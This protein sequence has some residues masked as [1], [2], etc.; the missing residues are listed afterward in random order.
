MIELENNLSNEYVKKYLKIKKRS[1]FHF[2][3]FSLTVMML[4]YIKILVVFNEPLPIYFYTFIISLS[5]IC[6]YLL[7]REYNAANIKEIIYDNSTS[8]NLV[9]IQF[10]KEQI[11]LF[12]SDRTYCIHVNKYTNT[13][14]FVLS[15][16]DNVIFVSINT[17]FMLSL[18]NLTEEQ[19]CNLEKLFQYYKSN[20]HMCPV[21]NEN[22]LFECKIL[23]TR[24]KHILYIIQNKLKTYS[25]LRKFDI[26]ILILSI[27]D[28]F[29]IRLHIY[30]ILIVRLIIFLMYAI[31][32]ANTRYKYDIQSGYIKQKTKIKFTSKHYIITVNDKIISRENIDNIFKIEKLKNTYYIQTVSDRLFIQDQDNDYLK[33]IMKKNK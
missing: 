31:H 17:I 3:C 23:N 20:D 33:K 10:T 1:G 14:N 32:T 6:L 12:Y 25:N 16:D 4:I 29:T 24:L 13:P 22:E 26:I 27:I 28:I 7:F 18:N 11:K 19:W 30:A 9:K 8:R 21:Q 2:R 15:K 5:I